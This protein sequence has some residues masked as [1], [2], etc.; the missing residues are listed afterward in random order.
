MEKLPK[1]FKDKWI[2]ALRSGEYEQGAMALCY[3]D[4]KSYCCLGVA[5]NVFMGYDPYDTTSGYI[6]GKTREQAIEQGFPEILTGTGSKNVIVNHLAK[7]NDGVGLEGS[8]SF[9]EI[10]DYIEANL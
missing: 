5:Y 1:E 9:S 7:M 6:D 10:A 8:K 3:P 2:A 4:K